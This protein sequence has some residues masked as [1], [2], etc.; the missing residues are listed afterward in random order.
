MENLYGLDEML[1]WYHRLQGTNDK[2]LV[3]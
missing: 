1:F 3:F 2:I